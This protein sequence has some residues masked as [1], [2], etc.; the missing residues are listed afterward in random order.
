[1]RAADDSPCSRPQSSRCWRLARDVAAADRRRRSKSSRRHD[2]RA[3]ATRARSGQELRLRRRTDRRPQA[4]GHRRPQPARVE[5]NG[6]WKADL[7]ALNENIKIPAKVYAEVKPLEPGDR[8]HDLQVPRRRLA[9][10][11]EIAGG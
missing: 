2:R 9:R 6:N 10:R 1:M 8:G 3:T 7:E 11:V 4:E 5:A